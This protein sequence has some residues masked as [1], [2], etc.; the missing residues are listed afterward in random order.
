MDQQ[1]DTVIRWLYPTNHAFMG[2]YSQ[3]SVN[4]MTEF[5]PTSPFEEQQSCVL[6]MQ[7]IDGKRSQ[8]EHGVRKGSH[9]SVT[10]QVAFMHIVSV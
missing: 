2:I 5:L 4:C 1:C 9:V 7:T 8:S 10:P 6:K 3:I